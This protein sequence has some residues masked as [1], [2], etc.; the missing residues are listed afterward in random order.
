MSSSASSVRPFGVAT[1]YAEPIWY[2][3]GKTPF[4]NDSHRKLRAEVRKYV[5]EEL[6]PYAFE[7]EQAGQV[8][9]KVIMTSLQVLRHMVTGYRSRSVMQI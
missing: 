2:S 9:E 1:P 5:D 6:I 3:R 8:P 4:Y 7:W